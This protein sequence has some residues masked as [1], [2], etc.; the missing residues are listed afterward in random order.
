MNNAYFNLWS[1]LAKSTNCREGW[2]NSSDKECYTNKG[3]EYRGK[4]ERERGERTVRGERKRE[5][6]KGQRTVR[7]KRK[8]GG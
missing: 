1:I 3:T 2:D 8:R 5:R 4:R 7:G 6:E